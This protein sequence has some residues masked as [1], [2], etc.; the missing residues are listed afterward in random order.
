MNESFNTFNHPN[1]P[2]NN[3][4][5]QM[6]N[7]KA[8]SFHEESIIRTHKDILDDISRNL[9]DLDYYYLFNSKLKKAINELIHSAWNNDH[10]S[11]RIYLFYL[12]F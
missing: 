7:Q 3:F 5:N 6:K 1:L 4:N 12:I 2:N 10:E 9:R 11:I 8:L